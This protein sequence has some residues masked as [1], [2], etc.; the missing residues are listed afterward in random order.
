ML[1]FFGKPDSI[2]KAKLE[3]L[4][5][6]LDFLTLIVVHISLIQARHLAEVIEIACVP[7]HILATPVVLPTNK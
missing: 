2:L 3:S 6:Q 1:G 5:R 4:Q 7:E